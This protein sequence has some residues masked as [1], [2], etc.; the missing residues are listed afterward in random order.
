[1]AKHDDEMRKHKADDEKGVNVMSVEGNSEVY[2]EV[3]IES[4]TKSMNRLCAQ[5]EEGSVYTGESFPME[6]QGT[7]VR[8]QQGRKA[9]KYYRKG[10]GRKA[11]KYSRK[12]QGW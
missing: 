4:E 5:N 7:R 8:K 6:T 10:R 3:P 11:S 12:R 9:R 1:M 2:M